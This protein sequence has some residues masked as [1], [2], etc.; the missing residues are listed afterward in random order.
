MK[1]KINLKT[2]I[3]FVILIL[4]VILSVL[5]V[6]TVRTYMS[7]AT[8]GIEP[9][10]IQEVL[11]D[12]G[13]SATI[14]WVSDKESMGTVYYGTNAASILVTSI[15][16]TQTTNHAVVLNNLRANT[17][18][19]FKLKIEESDFDNNGMPFSFTTKGSSDA[20]TDTPER[21]PS[22]VMNNPSP[23]VSSPSGMVLSPTIALSPVS[24]TS[25]TTSPSSGAASCNKSTD[26]NNDGVTN[27]MDYLYCMKNGS[28]GSTTTAAPTGASVGVCKH[29]V[30]YNNDG[31]VNTLDYIK[32]L[33]SN[34]K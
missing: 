34:K 12:D 14:T 25:S 31:I 8:A 19:Y 24:T 16:S 22:R 21:M 30:D 13:K 2:I 28:G 20:N 11:S 33:Q 17:K 32:C 4:V 15:E 6:K 23:E 10:N 7:G 29:D 9:K 27:T 5:G 1:G 26:Y 18:Y 3:V